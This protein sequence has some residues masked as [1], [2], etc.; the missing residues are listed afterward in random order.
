MNTL[1]TIF[2]LGICLYTLREVQKEVITVK[3]MLSEI[4]FIIK[5]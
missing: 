3:K 4:K 5:D 1:L 2:M